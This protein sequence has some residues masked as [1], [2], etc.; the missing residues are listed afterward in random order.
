MAIKRYKPTSP[1]RRFMSVSDFKEITS[2]K[3]ERSLLA[4][5]SAQAAETIWAESPYAISAAATAINTE[6]LTLRETR[7]TSPPRSS[8]YN[9]TQQKRKYRTAGVCGRREEIYTC[10]SGT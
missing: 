7:T 3:P 8:P 9:T 6:L 5:K 4:P 1:A 2:D 10:A